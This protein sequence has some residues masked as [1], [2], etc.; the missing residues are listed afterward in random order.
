METSNIEPNEEWGETYLDL[1]AQHAGE[2]RGS[3]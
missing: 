3:R 1:T 2:F